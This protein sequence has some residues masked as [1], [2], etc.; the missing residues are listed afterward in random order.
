MPIRIVATGRGSAPAVFCDYCEKQI[1]RA[2]DGNVEWRALEVAETHFTHKQCSDG[3]R[4][5]RPELTFFSTELSLFPLR[6]AYAL[7][8]DIDEAQASL[9]RLA[10]SEA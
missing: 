3:F 6:L 8:V 7:K 1:M 2:D 10:D 4:G 9:E 5:T